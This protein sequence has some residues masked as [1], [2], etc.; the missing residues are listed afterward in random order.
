MKDIILKIMEIGWYL[1]FTGI[2]FLWGVEVGRKMGIQ[3][4][5]NQKIELLKI[6]E[7]DSADWWRKGEKP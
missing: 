7:E 2:G 5:L 1:L 4:T 6:N 3:I